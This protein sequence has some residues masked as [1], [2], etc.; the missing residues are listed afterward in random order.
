MSCRET[1]FST[2]SKNAQLQ[3]IIRTAK[4]EA[5]DTEVQALLQSSQLSRSHEALPNALAT[6]TY[7][8]HLIDPC[9]KAGVYIE[10]AAR[11]ESAQVLWQEGE[12]SSSIRILQE[13]C[14]NAS[15]KSQVHNAP[16]PDLLATLVRLNLYLQASYHCADRLIGTPNRRSSFS[17]IRRN[18]W[19]VSWS[20]H[21]RI[22]WSN[23]RFRRGQSISRIRFVLRSTTPKP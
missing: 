21:Q 8:N 15:Q 6:A 2:I 13:L 7:L 5:L 11:Y 4:R 17:K 10:A 16:T 1:I 14:D 19:S 20:C 12:M 3:S 22:T 9:Y 23:D 18:H